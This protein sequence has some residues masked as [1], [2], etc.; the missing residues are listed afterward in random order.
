MYALLKQ[1]G[2]RCKL[3]KR[4][5]K[6]ELVIGAQCFSLLFN[7]VMQ[8]KALRPE[9]TGL[10]VLYHDFQSPST[11]THLSLAGGCLFSTLYSLLVENNSL[12]LAK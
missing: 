10:F 12:K 5:L 3:L 8:A 7:K 6:I 1:Q 11:L 9:V 4:H 2:V